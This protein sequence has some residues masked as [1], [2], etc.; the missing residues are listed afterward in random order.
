MVLKRLEQIEL[1][2]HK[3]FHNGKVD[4]NYLNI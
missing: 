2:C 1:S 4:Y 3:C